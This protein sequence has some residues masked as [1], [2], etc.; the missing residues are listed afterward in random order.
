MSDFPAEMMKQILSAPAIVMRSTRY[1]LT[2]RGRSMLPSNRPPTGSNSFENASGWMRVPAPA[3]GMMP[4]MRQ[5]QFRVRSQEAPQV[6]APDALMNDQP[7][8]ARVP[9][10][11]FSRAYSGL[12]TKRS[13]H[14]QSFRQP[15]FL[16]PV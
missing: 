1:S 16:R 4:S 6:P 12:T 15:G 2:A 8:F 9:P 11:Q 7:A 3:A 10:S 14:R 5:L 13:E